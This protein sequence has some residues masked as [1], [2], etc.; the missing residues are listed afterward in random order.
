MLFVRT[1]KA[2]P[3]SLGGL[4]NFPKFVYLFFLVALND[5]YNF[6]PAKTSCKKNSNTK[7]S[8][9]DLTNCAKGLAVFSKFTVGL[10]GNANLMTAKQ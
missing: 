9:T 1:P 4:K 2:S 5:H 7:T 6:S 10:S 3:L 8:K